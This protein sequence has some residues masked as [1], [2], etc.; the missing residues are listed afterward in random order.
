MQFDHF[1]YIFWRKKGVF[2]KIDNEIMS[3]TSTKKIII[4]YN[5]NFYEKIFIQFKK[6][7]KNKTKLHY[8]L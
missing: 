3:I 5:F 4:I 7:N 2:I 1:H 6:F 8:F